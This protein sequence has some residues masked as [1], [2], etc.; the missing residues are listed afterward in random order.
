VSELD[1]R[2]R[3]LDAERQRPMTAE[4]DPLWQVIDVLAHMLRD[5]EHQE[6]R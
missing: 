6:E 1:E 5:A 3:S 4:P 2:I